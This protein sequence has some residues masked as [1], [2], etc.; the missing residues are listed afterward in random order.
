[1]NGLVIFMKTQSK[2]IQTDRAH[3]KSKYTYIPKF[4]F[5]NGYEI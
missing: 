4:N 5:K 1:M 3:G 2:S